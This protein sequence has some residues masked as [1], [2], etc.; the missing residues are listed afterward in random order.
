MEITPKLYEFTLVAFLNTT[1]VVYI[2]NLGITAGS[3]A[4][5]ADID[6]KNM[7]WKYRQEL[8]EV[9]DE[10]ELGNLYTFKSAGK[11][12]LKDVAAEGDD[13][14]DVSTA[15]RRHA[16]LRRRIEKRGTSVFWLEDRG[17]AL[18]DL[19]SKQVYTQKDMF[20]PVVMEQFAERREKIEAVLERAGDYLENAIEYDRYAIFGFDLNDEFS[21]ELVAYYGAL[22][23]TF[24]EN[25]FFGD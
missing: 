21:F 6:C 20:E 14:L 3:E 13:P 11:M 8:A 19:Q 17:D 18:V 25:I 22:I 15:T 16:T 23:L 7:V 12:K 4:N 5:E 10:I 9:A 1:V 24:V 2:V